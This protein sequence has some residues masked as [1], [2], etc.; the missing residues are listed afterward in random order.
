M[1]T[2]YMCNNVYRLLNNI[3]EDQA[4]GDFLR[5]IMDIYCLD[6]IINRQSAELLELQ[7]CD[8]KHLQSLS[9]QMGELCFELLDYSDVYTSTIQAP[10]PSKQMQQMAQAF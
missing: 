6:I 1:G 7:V 2:Q 8:D 5:K 10:K 4:F 9:G 3:N